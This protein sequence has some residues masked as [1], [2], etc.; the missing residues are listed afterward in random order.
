MHLW[1]SY[2]FVWSWGSSVSVVSDYRL[3]DWATGVRSLAEAKDFSYSLCVQ[4]SSDVHPA[5]CPMD[6]GV[7]SPW[8]ICDQGVTLTAHP[9]L[10]LMSRIVACMVVAGQLFSFFSQGHLF[11]LV[12]PEQ[13]HV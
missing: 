12:R 7:L 1:Y 9:H 8:V 5:S 11:S 6:T 2:N 4:T 3:E 10:V 13:C